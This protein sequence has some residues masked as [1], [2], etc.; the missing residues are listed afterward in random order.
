MRDICQV[1]RKRGGFGVFFPPFLFIYLAMSVLCKSSWVRGLTQATVNS[2][3]LF[4]VKA[5]ENGILG[6]QQ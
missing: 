4:L 5:N 3:G 1:D 2:F 6:R